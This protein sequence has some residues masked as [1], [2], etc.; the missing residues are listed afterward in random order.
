MH[1]FTE[2][3]TCS[4]PRNTFPARLSLNSKPLSSCKQ[5]AIFLNQL[6][7]E[8]FP[9]PN[10]LL[11]STP[12]LLWA[13][14]SDNFKLLYFE[15]K[16][17]KAQVLTLYD[18]NVSGKIF[19]QIYMDQVSPIG[20]ILSALLRGTVLATINENSNYQLW[21]WEV[22]TQRKHSSDDF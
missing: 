10:N 1:V 15:A 21:A 16:Q 8:M 19:Q 7:R 5:M 20:K 22:F 4:L 13:K 18:S 12:E 3:L 6:C 2:L 17:S 9:S 11:S 14:A